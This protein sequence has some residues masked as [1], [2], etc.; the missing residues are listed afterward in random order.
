[1]QRLD[2]T[3]VEIL[4]MLLLLASITY[5]FEG[6]TVQFRHKIDRIDIYRESYNPGWTNYYYCLNIESSQA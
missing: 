2:K 5:T 1:M 4:I 3:S 6:G